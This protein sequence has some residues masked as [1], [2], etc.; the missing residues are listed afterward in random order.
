[1]HLNSD[2]NVLKMTFILAQFKSQEKVILN[3]S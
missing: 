2:S 3:E 1:M